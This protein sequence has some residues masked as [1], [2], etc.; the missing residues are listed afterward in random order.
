MMARYLDPREQPNK[1]LSATLKGFVNETFVGNEKAKDALLIA[2]Q[3]ICVGVEPGFIE[4]IFS[5]WI[6]QY[7]ELIDKSNQNNCYP[8]Q[9]QEDSED[10]EE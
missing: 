1:W 7:C 3:H 10:T 2:V 8:L 5:E 4:D 9:D 6:N